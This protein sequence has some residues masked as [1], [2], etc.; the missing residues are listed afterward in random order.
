M[1]H[2]KDASDAALDLSKHLVTVSSA[3]LALGATVLSKFDGAPGW[4]FVVLGLSWLLLAGAIVFAMRTVST[5]VMSRLKVNDDWS[6]GDGEFAARAAR[7]AFVGGLALFAVFALMAL[8][9]AQPAERARAAKNGQT[10]SVGVA[11]LPII[12]PFVS[13]SAQ[14]TNEGS[15]AL[16]RASETLVRL[17]A[18][19]TVVEVRIV[20]AADRRRLQARARRAWA[21][22]AALARRRAIVVRDSLSRRLGGQASRI[23]WTTAERA[24]EHLDAPGDSL[25]MSADRSVQVVVWYRIGN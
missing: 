7:W 14:L 2:N 10:V 13:G 19:S 9:G 22:N 16:S 23:E 8:L 5:I 18:T 1:N 25:L 20:G 24:P 3:A 6:A 17:A 4:S 11:S 12:C 21:S 15:M